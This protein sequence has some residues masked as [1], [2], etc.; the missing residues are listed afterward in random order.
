MRA[1]AG[2]EALECVARARGEVAERAADCP[3]GGLCS[4]WEFGPY[5]SGGGGDVA[6]VVLGYVG[7]RREFLSYFSG[8]VSDGGADLASE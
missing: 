4:G 6:E 7:N 1:G 2:G 3:G 5:G 8:D